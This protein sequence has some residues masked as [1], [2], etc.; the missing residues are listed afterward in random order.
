MSAR[1][2]TLIGG[3]PW[4]FRM[5]GGHDLHQPLRISRVSLFIDYFMI[6][7]TVNIDY[8]TYILR[9]SV[10]FLRYF[11][12]KYIYHY[13]VDRRFIFIS[14]SRSDESLYCC[15][16]L[17]INCSDVAILFF[18]TNKIHLF[19][20]FIISEKILYITKIY[21]MKYIQVAI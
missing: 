3:S 7:W 19:C 20:L 14:Q 8:L 1:E 13:Y 12:V 6:F 10:L 18:Y 17:L 21:N 9:K 15:H 5:H 2:V 11:N 4:G 16:F